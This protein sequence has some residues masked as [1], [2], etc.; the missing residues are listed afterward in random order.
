MHSFLKGA[1]LPKANL[2]EG[3]S[4]QLIIEAPWNDNITVAEMDL[5]ALEASEHALDQCF[6]SLPEPWAFL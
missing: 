6:K 5:I 2:R 4:Q 1:S 3:Y